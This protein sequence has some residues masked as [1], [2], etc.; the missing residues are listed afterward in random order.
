MAYDYAVHGAFY[1]QQLPVSQ[2]GGEK[3]DRG[4]FTFVRGTATSEKNLSVK[5]LKNY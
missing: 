5:S 1:K 3:K 2:G 4:M